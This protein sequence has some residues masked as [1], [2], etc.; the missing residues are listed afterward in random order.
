[1]GALLSIVYLSIMKGIIKLN[2]TKVT[3]TIMVKI[4]PNPVFGYYFVGSTKVT[5]NWFMSN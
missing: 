4:V 1:M 3:I 2:S 5:F